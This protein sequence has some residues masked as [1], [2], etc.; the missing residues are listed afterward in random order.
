MLFCLL[1]Q[2]VDILTRVFI[3]SIFHHD[4]LDSWSFWKD[5]E[6]NSLDKLCQVLQQHLKTSIRLINPIK[7]HGII[8]LHT[9]EGQ[10][11]FNT[12][13]LFHNTSNQTFCNVLN[14][15][16]RQERSLQVHLSKLWLAV[17]SQVLVT[18]AFNNL[19]I[20]VE[21]SI[22]QELFGNLRTLGQSVKMPLM[23]PTRHQ[24]ITRS[25]WCWLR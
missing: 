19:V 3:C 10:R 4:S 14:L 22:H 21:T 13:G 17:T 7:S 15:L 20:T 25:F 9:R 23:N 16:I 12:L 24:V 18:E 1:C 6:V 8:I 2:L 5:L 11:K